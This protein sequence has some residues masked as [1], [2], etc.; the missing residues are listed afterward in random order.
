[1]EILVIYKIHNPAQGMAV[2]LYVMRELQ[3]AVY[4]SRYAY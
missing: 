1:M 2:L 3:I 4:Y